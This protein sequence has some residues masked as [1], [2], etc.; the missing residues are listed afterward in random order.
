MRRRE[1]TS[2]KSSPSVG[3][4]ALIALVRLLARQAAREFALH[5]PA[6]A[7]RKGASGH[8]LAPAFS[9]RQRHRAPGGCLGQDGEALDRGLDASVNESARRAIGAAERRRTTVLTPDPRLGRPQ[10][11]K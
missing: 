2:T 1:P 10:R 4:D 8:D 9:A 5:A 7:A 6:H 3:L 11:R